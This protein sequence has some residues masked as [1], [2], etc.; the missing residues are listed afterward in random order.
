[1][2]LTQA[3]SEKPTETIE[4][5]SYGIRLTRFNNGLSH[6]SYLIKP[7]DLAALFVT[8]VRFETGILRD[9]T[10]YVAEENNQR[11][12]IEYRPAAITGIWLESEPNM[13]HVPLPSLLLRRSVATDGSNPAY[14]MYAT[15]ETKNTIQL[16]TKLYHTPLPNVFTSGNICWGNIKRQPVEFDDNSL[17][18]GWNQFLNTHFNGHG[19]SGKTRT[20]HSDVRILLTELSNNKATEFPTEELIPSDKTLGDLIAS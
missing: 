12:T 1:M 13:L 10:L 8:H 11:I 3:L 9:N 5:F 17:A 18:A 14:T 20:H 2:T 19:A 15:T 7:E 4:V 16:T 6:K